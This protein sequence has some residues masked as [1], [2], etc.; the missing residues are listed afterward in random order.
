ML[1]NAHNKY[2]HYNID[3]IYISERLKSLRKILFFCIENKIKH[4]RASFTIIAIET[5]QTE[6]E[7]KFSLDQK[8]EELHTTNMSHNLGL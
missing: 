6:S 2:H 1:E 7:R 3:L 5:Q 4:T 8:I